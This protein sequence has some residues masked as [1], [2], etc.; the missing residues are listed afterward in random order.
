MH[1]QYGKEDVVEPALPSEARRLSDGIR[2]VRWSEEIP[3][4]LNT[5]AGSTAHRGGFA[6]A[7]SGIRFDNL[8]IDRGPRLPA[9][10]R[11]RRQFRLRHDREV[12]VS[13]RITETPVCTV[14]RDP[15]S[16]PTC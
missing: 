9:M 5:P 2:V 12:A 6:A 4:I 1:I 10:P 8:I 15:R 11:L 3:A 14:C 7:G 16:W 13:G